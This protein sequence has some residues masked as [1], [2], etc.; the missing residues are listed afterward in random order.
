MSEAMKIIES[1]FNPAKPEEPMRLPETPKREDLLPFLGKRLRSK[2]L[3]KKFLD[4]SDYYLNNKHF[5]PVSIA[6][7]YNFKRWAAL[8]KICA[9][10]IFYVLSRESLTRKILTSQPVLTFQQPEVKVVRDIEYPTLFHIDAVV[11]VTR[12][13]CSFSVEPIIEVHEDETWTDANGEINAHD[14]KK[15]LAGIGELLTKRK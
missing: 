3:R 13:D 12:M 7:E 8:G 15:L 4:H 5:I 11:P 6:K 10:E 14:E 1:L 2:R 9:E